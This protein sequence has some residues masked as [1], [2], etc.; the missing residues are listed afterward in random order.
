MNGLT[1][2]L[3]KLVAL[4]SSE[5]C[6]NLVVALLHTLWQGL[7]IAGALYVYL[8]HAP[9]ESMNKRYGA[10]VMALVVVVLC[11]LL[12]W[13]IL[14]Y[15]APVTN[16]SSAAVASVGTPD[17]AV[18]QTAESQTVGAL[19]QASISKR[20]V[21]TVSTSADAEEAEPSRRA[22]ASEL[23]D[24]EAAGLSGRG[25]RKTAV[26]PKPSQTMGW[27]AWAIGAWII[28]A[29]VMLMRAMAVMVG[30]GR[31][32]KRCV[33]LE[34]ETLLRLVGTLRRKMQI[35]RRIRVVV[36]EHVSVPGVVGCFWPTL[37][38]PVSMVSGVPADELQAILTHEL[39][40]IR[41]WDYLVN[42][43]QMVIEAMLFFNPAVWWVS[44]QIRI[45]REACC[46]AVGVTE[47][48]HRTR[49]AQVLVSWAQKAR[50][51]HM[52][53]AAAIVGF[54]E[55]SGD[56]RVLDRVKRIMVAGHK[57]R[58]RVSWPIAGLMLVLSIACLAA[59]W[60][61]T[62]LAV[63]VAGKVLTPQERIEKID[64]IS[65]EY[66][67]EDR[68]FGAE[69]YIHISGTVRT[70]DGGP[71][72][73]Y[74]NALVHSDRPSYG[75]SSSIG[76]KTKN[77][78][79]GVGIF[80]SNVEYGRISVIVVA[81]GYAPA[82]AGP[83]DRE[84]G[85]KVEGIELV[86]GEGFPGRL[87]VVD[88][89]GQ[90]VE[91]AEIFGGYVCP[92]SGSYHHTIKLTTDE[93]GIAVQEHAGQWK[94]G[95]QIE[96][97]GFEPEQL[98][99][100]LFKP[101]ETSVIALKATEPATGVVVSQASGEPVEG[102]EVR[103]MMSRI[104]SHTYGESGMYGEADAVTDADGQFVL[105]R[106]IG[107]RE[108]LVLFRA[109]GYGHKYMT[110][111]K[112][113]DGDVRVA[114]G[115]KRVI[116]GTVTGAL[117][118]LSTDRDGKPVVRYCSKFGF[119]HSTSSDSAEKCPVTI[120]D[121]VGYFEIE[122]FHGQHV[123]ITAGNTR[124]GGKSISVDVENDDLDNV[125]IDLA[126]GDDLKREVVMVFK[127][128]EGSPA[129]QGGVRT[130]HVM[131]GE[132]GYRPGWTD[133]VDSEARCEVRVPCRFKYQVD[134]YHGKRPVGYWFK[135]SKDVEIPAGEE[136][137]VIEVPVHPAGAI[138][139]TILR[140]DGRAATNAGAS[141]IVAKKPEVAGEGLN[142]LN[143]ALHGGG[144]DKGTFNATP[145]PLGGKY[146]IVAY[147]G[148]YFQ[149]TG[150]FVLDE[151]NQIIEHDIQF[152]EAV[153]LKGRL[154]DIDGTPARDNV[155][156]TASAKAGESSWST[157]REEIRPDENGGFCFENV[158]PDFAGKHFV[159]VSVGPGYRPV[160]LEVEDVTRPLVIQL[161]KGKLL[162]GVVIDDATGWPV[163]KAQVYAYY[164][165]K[166]GD[167]Y[168]YENLEAQSST[169]E[170]GEFVFS[171]MAAREYR[172]GVRS[173]NLADARSP[174]RGTGGQEEPLILRIDIREWS[175]LKPRE[176]KPGSPR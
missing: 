100:V 19:E 171:N 24:A 151:K 168:E 99:E 66:G 92:G 127:V 120:E 118:R 173:A 75:S 80:D 44:R 31:L 64:E 37:L 67:F 136:P 126:T 152:S 84:P 141:L 58:L 90:A 166:K 169:N 38:L 51:G 94:T 122:G 74:P 47:I 26:T 160:K 18:S 95:L 87:Q 176:P 85:G 91:G 140:S 23:E 78:P 121:G 11:G 4:M 30:G 129:M 115:E 157:D 104:D 53:A 46:D 3:D 45:E 16:D 124:A 42:F 33:P 15:D 116:R 10:S 162:R 83:F 153:A 27:Q 119:K 164:H 68:E 35:G 9:A 81:D 114:L 154:I 65:Q 52:G 63:A 12:T 22:A 17:K 137:F 130:D 134:Y 62:D 49:Y 149:L 144:I 155:K 131:E 73:K 39:A 93:N 36:G 146:A 28:G 125:V 71:L 69:D 132:N 48:G 109:E 143:A 102:A 159:K 98:R 123:E 135:E 1:V 107:N 133:I 128:P 172:L 79:Q 175:D 96:A 76:M 41:R 40:H 158:N 113:G 97:D 117:E 163:P 110:G 56:G 156:L 88:E 147:E 103:V 8:R 174:V 6:R 60:Q 50:D 7:V 32:R 29:S 142:D 21:T 61:G 170:R 138:Y 34:D 145:L 77:Q 72:P 165:A 108:Y 59:L 139:G 25:K 161:E 43:C 54:A 89:S 82:M 112:P 20:E 55:G 105:G 111:I 150:I 14:N 13:S 70:H 167:T 86:L 5:F 148:N 106:L 101:G 2:L 57:P